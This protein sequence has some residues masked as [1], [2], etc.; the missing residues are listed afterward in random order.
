[1][2][3]GVGIKHDCDPLEP[4]CDLREQLKPLAS[5]RGFPGGKA[6][7]VSARAIELRDDAAGDG[8]GHVC[9]DN[10]DRPRL[11]LE[12]K[13]RRGRGCTDDIGLQA[14]QLFRERSHLIDVCAVPPNFHSHVAANGPT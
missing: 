12:G 8:V 11:P 5:E 10:R 2:R 4:G 13:D 3:G 7:D 9:K 14:D 6:G 1:M